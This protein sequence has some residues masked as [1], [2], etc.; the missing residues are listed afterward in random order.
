[1]NLREKYVKTQRIY[2]GKIIKLDVDTVTLPDGNEATRELVRHPGGVGIV[3]LDSDDN[4]YLVRQYRRPYDEIL[5]EIPAGKLD[6]GENPDCAATRELSEET[7]FNCGNLKF[8]GSFYPSVGFLD[9]N[10]RMYLA[11]ELTKGKMHTDDDEFLNLEKM[12]FEDAVNLVMSG[13][14]KD[15]KTIAAILKVKLMRGL[16]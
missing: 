4:I 12:P 7:G 10:L 6:V 15:G 16:Q 11:T 13:E 1:M 9:E 5:L 2:N 14:I 8:I 3:A